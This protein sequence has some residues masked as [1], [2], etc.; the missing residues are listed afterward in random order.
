MH[1]RSTKYIRRSYIKD[2]TSSASVYQLKKHIYD[3]WLWQDGDS[4]T[5][6][7]PWQSEIRGHPVLRRRRHHSGLLPGPN[8][9]ILQPPPSLSERQQRCLWRSR[10]HT[11]QE[12]VGLGDLPHDT[13]QR[14]SRPV[15]SASGTHS[16][17]L[18]FFFER[19]Y[20]L[21]FSFIYPD[22]RWNSNNSVVQN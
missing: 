5:D 8:V 15:D 22:L 16:S 12:S 19:K 1:L 2:K 10:R 11:T 9:Q 20:T 7:V 4:E 18:F 17:F 14:S 3:L 6:S 13:V 21:F